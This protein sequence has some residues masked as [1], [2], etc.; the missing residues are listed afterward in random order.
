MWAP[1]FSVP[2]RMKMPKSSHGFHRF[3]YFFNSLLISGIRGV[4][5]FPNRWEITKMDKRF[6]FFMLLILA[7][8]AS[9][10]VFAEATQ[11][12][13]SSRAYVGHENDRD[14]QNFISQYPNAAGTRLDDCQTCH[15]SGIKGTDTEREFSPCG[16]CHLLQYPNAKYKTGVPRNFEQTLN[17]YGVAYKQQGRTAEALGAISK[18]DSDGDGFANA[19]EIAD[20]RNPGD[21]SSRLSQPLAPTVTLSRDDIR[22]LPSHSQF[23]LM[24]ASHELVDEYVNYTGVRVVDLLQA[25]KVNLTGAIGITVFA[26]D[27][28]S[29]DY[30]I[31]DVTKPFPKG[32]YYAGLGTLENKEVSFVHY[33]ESIPRG[34]ANGKEIPDTLWLLLAFERDGKPLDSSRYEKGTGK[35]AGEGPYRLVKPQRN[36]MG[37]PSK[38]GR[39]DRSVKSKIFNDDWDYDKDIDHNAGFCVRGATVIRVNPVPEGFEEFDWKNSWSLIADGRIV[40]YGHGITG[41]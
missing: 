22:K 11:E 30:V 13:A 24:N 34:I 41:K 32:F 33:P 8:A 15:R 39:P 25:A 40:V 17:A 4:F 2:R 20:L 6:R 21:P 12:T 38:P 19:E 14:I 10:I 1:V 16:Y 23:M 28:Y 36:L 37:D 26:P 7:I 29:I 31:E 27:G 5:C 9:W 3:H 35:L 18:L